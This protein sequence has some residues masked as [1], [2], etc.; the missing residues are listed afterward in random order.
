MKKSTI[1]ILGIV[2]GLSFLSLLYLQVSYIEE[3][4]KMRREQFDE[5]VRRSL[6]QACRNIELVETKKYLEDDVVATERA[7]QLYRQQ[8]AKEGKDENELVAHTQHY[9]V[10]SDGLDGYSTFELKMKISTNRPANVPK[11]IISTGKNIPQTARALQEIIKERYVYQRALLD[12]VVYT[13]LRTASD[14]PLKERVNFKQLD[15][16]I[17]TELLNNGIDIPSMIK[18]GVHPNT[19]IPQGDVRSIKSGSRF[20]TGAISSRKTT[21]IYQAINGTE[22]LAAR[23]IVH[24]S[25]AQFKFLQTVHLSAQVSNRIIYLCITQTGSKTHGIQRHL[26]INGNVLQCQLV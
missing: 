16:F 1:W 8:A 24:R 7:A 11:A 2:M 9:A 25:T 19:N 26:Q 22:Q 10:S 20:H 21:G 13:I 14:K 15:L 23:V 3:M 17:K 12:E 6:D 4:V 18:H 5:S